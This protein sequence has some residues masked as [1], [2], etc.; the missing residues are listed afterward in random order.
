MYET[1]PGIIFAYRLHVIRARRSGLATG[2]FEHK[3]AFMTGTGHRD[4][5]PLV[6]VEATEAEISDDIEM[7]IAFQK[8]DCGED[9]YCI[10]Q[11]PE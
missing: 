2:V 7:I 1:A 8:K 4:D 6:I 11:G 3:S 5:E 9:G 10:Y